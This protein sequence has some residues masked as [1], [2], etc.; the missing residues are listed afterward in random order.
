MLGVCPGHPIPRFSRVDGSSRF[1]VWLFHGLARVGVWEGIGCVGILLGPEKTSPCVR[2]GV[3]R[4]GVSGFS[5]VVPASPGRITPLSCVGG[6]WLGWVGVWGVFVEN[7][8]VDASIFVVKLLR[9][10]GGCLGTRSR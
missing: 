3:V 6:W 10:H 8:T 2:A 5:W 1:T 4:S 9:A 7:C